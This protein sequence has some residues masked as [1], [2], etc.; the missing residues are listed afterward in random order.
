METFGLEQTTMESARFTKDSITFVGHTYTVQINVRDIY[1]SSGIVPICPSDHHLVY[2][3]KISVAHKMVIYIW[4]AQIRKN[5]KKIIF[6]RDEWGIECNNVKS[7]NNVNQMW[8]IFNW[9][10]RQTY[11]NKRTLLLGDSNK[12]INDDFLFEIRQIDSIYPQALKSRHESDW[13]LYRSV[14]TLIVKWSVRL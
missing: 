1:C 9:N 11:A 7:F 4:I 2:V 5:K 14:K 12:S 10:R 8:S 6:F 3:G 13:V